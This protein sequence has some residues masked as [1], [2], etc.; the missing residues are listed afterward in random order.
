MKKIFIVGIVSV[1]L[2]CSDDAELRRSVFIPDPDAPGLPKYSEWGY[3]TFGAFYNRET[4]VSNDYQ[5][6]VQVIQQ[7]NTTVFQ[8]RGQKGSNYY[9]SEDFFEIKLTIQDFQ[10]ANY[11]DLMS[12]HG[13]VIDL[14]DERYSISIEDAYS[15]Y[16]VELLSGTFEFKRA[17][18]LLVDGEPEEVILS[19]VFEF[20]AM[21]DG[22]PV[23]ISE[24]RFDVGVGSY[25]FFVYD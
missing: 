20:Q 2:A 6:P 12:L 14:A 16:D 3:N 5:V 24:G 11:Q 25:N 9:W 19:G 4:I 18:H 10:P 21:I 1:L 13:Q 8:F 17:Q 15:T 7:F 23:S 22:E